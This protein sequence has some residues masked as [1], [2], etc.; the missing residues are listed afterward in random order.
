[1]D[2]ETPENDRREDLR[3]GLRGSEWCAIVEVRGY[4]GGAQ[5]ND[6]MRIERFATRYAADVGKPPDS[7]WYIVNQFVGRDPDQRPPMLESNPVE[8]ADFAEAGG[9]VADTTEIFRLA[10]DVESGVLTQ[11]SARRALLDC[12]GRFTAS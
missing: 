4:K 8:L 7:R 12:R 2:R 3:V 11:E 6:L 10:R 1:M 5:V 9:L